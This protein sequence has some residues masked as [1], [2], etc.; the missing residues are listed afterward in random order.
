MLLGFYNFCT[1]TCYPPN[2]IFIVSIHDHQPIFVP[3]STCH[4]YPSGCPMWAKDLIVFRGLRIFFHMFSFVKNILKSYKLN[5]ARKFW[6]TPGCEPEFE[7][8][9]SAW[10]TVD[11]TSNLPRFI[12]SFRYHNK[13]PLIWDDIKKMVK[14]SDNCYVSVLDYM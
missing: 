14:F 3:C 5:F 11:L 7:P 2:L 13:I 1:P 10:E 8:T 6:E 9:I 12:F 4:Y